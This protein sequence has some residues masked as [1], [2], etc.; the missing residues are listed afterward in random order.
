M[1]ILRKLLE[2]QEQ[3]F[4]NDKEGAQ[5]LLTV[6]GSPAPKQ[7]KADRVAATTALV[8]ALLNFDES[9]TQR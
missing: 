9:I 7:E 8:S 5:K 6:G 4:Q 3:H 1:G 2:E